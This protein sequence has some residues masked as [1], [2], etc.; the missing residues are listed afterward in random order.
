MAK[1]QRIRESLEGNI[2][3]EHLKQRQEAGWRIVGVEWERVTEDDTV[4]ASVAVQDA[5]FGSRV[6]GDCEHLEENPPEMQFL[7]SLM[8]LII[9]NISLTNIPEELNNK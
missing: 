7:L 8:E 3:P 5:P 4:C 2:N 9:Q 6:S 1:M